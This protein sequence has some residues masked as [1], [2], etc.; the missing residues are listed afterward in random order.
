MTFIIN[1]RS[2]KSKEESV[3]FLDAE[4]IR[5]TNAYKAIFTTETPLAKMFST[6]TALLISLCRDI[7]MAKKLVQVQA[8]IIAEL[9]TKKIS[10][11]TNGAEK[12]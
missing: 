7:S 1:G 5:Q 10:T 2:D 6:V 11:E 3:I 4:T 9:Q 12:N 8:E